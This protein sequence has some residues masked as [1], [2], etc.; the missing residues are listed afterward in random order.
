MLVLD[1]A[2]T[3]LD[4]GFIHDIKLIINKTNKNRQTL[5]FSATMN[6]DILSISKEFMHNPITVNIES[7]KLTVDKVTQEVY[8]VDKNNKTNLLLDLISTED[9]PSTLIFT[10]TKHGANKLEDELKEF[11]ITASVIHGNKTQSNR[12]KALQ[13]F[14]SGKNRIMIATDIAARGLDINDLGLVV[15]YDMPEQPEVYVHRIG[16]TA[17]AGKEGRAI[18]LCSSAET[19]I[20]NA[21]EKLIHQSIKEIEHKY[22]MV[23]K[24]DKPIRGRMNRTNNSNK[25]TKNNDR[26]TRD[27]RLGRSERPARD[28]KPRFSKDNGRDNK[29]GR[30]ERPTRDSKPRFNKDN[31]RDNKFG[32]SERPA[33]DSKPRFNKDNGRDNKFGRSERPARDSKP[34]FNKDNGRDNKFGRSERPARDSK[35]RFNK[36]SRRS[37]RELYT[38]GKPKKLDYKG[39]P[40]VK[41]NNNT[42]FGSIKQNRIYSR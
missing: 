30:S 28:S 37:N 32:R 8:F 40:V 35:L 1:E 15:N 33:R 23:L 42:R 29:F 25:S 7:N 34:R 16:R 14:K 4:M 22:P 19:D 12:V 17:R 13:D 38:D 27:N 20:L 2:D 11:D 3:M 21:V 9:K 6:K 41:K 18:S 26:P 31:G 39:S 5:L 36:D 24:E 10:R